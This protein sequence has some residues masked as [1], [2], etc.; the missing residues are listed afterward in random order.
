MQAKL[1]NES[2]LSCTYQ[3]ETQNEKKIQAR[4]C[5]RQNK[6]TSLSSWKQTR[7]TWQVNS[8]QKQ[9]SSW[10]S[11]KVLQKVSNQ[12]LQ[13]EDFWN[14]LCCLCFQALTSVTNVLVFD[15]LLVHF[16]S[17]WLPLTT[18]L[19]LQQS[20]AEKFAEL[21]DSSVSW[22]TETKKR[23]GEARSDSI[24]MEALTCI[25]SIR[26]LD[27]SEFE[28]QTVQSSQ[29][30][31]VWSR[32]W[33]VSFS[34]CCSCLL[35]LFL[36]PSQ[37]RCSK[38]EKGSV[39]F[40]RFR[41]SEQSLPCLFCSVACSRFSSRFVLMQQQR[42]EKRFEEDLEGGCCA[43]RAWDHGR[44]LVG[45]LTTQPRTKQRESRS[46]VMCLA[47]F[48]CLL[49]PPPLGIPSVRS[50][51][52]RSSVA[53]A[54]MRVV[55]HLPFSSPFRTP[56]APLQA[57]QLEAQ[58]TTAAAPSTQQTSP[59]T[60]STTATGAFRHPYDLPY[61]AGPARSLI[62]ITPPAFLPDRL[63]SSSSGAESAAS[64]SPSPSWCHCRSSHIY[65][66]SSSSRTECIFI[67]RL[68]GFSCETFIPSFCWVD[69]EWYHCFYCCISSSLWLSFSLRVS[70]QKNAVFQRHSKQTSKRRLNSSFVVIL[71][72]HLSSCSCSFWSF[73]S[74]FASDHRSSSQGKVLSFFW[75]WG[76][77]TQSNGLT[78]PFP[79]ISCPFFPHWCTARRGGQLIAFSLS[80][81]QGL[82]IEIWSHSLWKRKEDAEL[83][84]RLKMIC[85]LALSSYSPSFP[86][87]PLSLILVPLLIVCLPLFSSCMRPSR[88]LSWITK[89]FLLGTSASKSKNT[90]AGPLTEEE[91]R[92][93]KAKK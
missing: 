27:K 65:S 22:K 6:G 12:W 70:Q 49:L 1:F 32:Q 29:M 87:F 71:L 59:G 16:Q 85:D 69:C 56:S 33:S 92:E 4:Q 3:K 93:R 11:K 90:K 64:A 63:P 24:R 53:V 39:H 15:D 57:N 13:H 40:L 61:S 30:F 72:L 44:F 60:A 34:W 25:Y 9:H 76:S 19:F 91:V 17:T 51:F 88:E 77:D 26:S 83:I 52:R 18:L 81:K 62:Y 67:M 38:R 41:F 28:R 50:P 14:W 73:S 37:C 78:C 80:V 35:H 31:T 5:E 42:D 75:W 43:R 36:L 23:K 7:W 55:P 74:F 68:C 20:S 21:Q 48:F 89:F 47:F 54:S 84:E 66:F 2:T 46:I 82:R 45:A 10:F 79:S 58:E 86:S 8:K